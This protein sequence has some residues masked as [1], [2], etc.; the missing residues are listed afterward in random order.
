ME[1]NSNWNFGNVD[2]VACT[3]TTTKHHVV[4]GHN[5]Y[6]EFMEIGCCSFVRGT[7]AW[8]SMFVGVVRWNKWSR[9]PPFTIQT[10]NC[11]YDMGGGMRCGGVVY[12]LVGHW[13]SYCIIVFNLPQRNRSFIDY[14]NYCMDFGKRVMQHPQFHSIKCP[15]KAKKWVQCPI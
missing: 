15:E 1:R 2:A 7:M 9:W 4:V 10:K 11:N 14:T 6:A 13:S 5:H 8:Q 12:A 3:T